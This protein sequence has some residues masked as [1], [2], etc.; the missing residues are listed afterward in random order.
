MLYINT[1]MES[2]LFIKRCFDYNILSR[3]FKNQ[4]YNNVKNKHIII[5]ILQVIESGFFLLL[6]LLYF[7]HS[8]FLSYTY[9]SFKNTS[10]LYLLST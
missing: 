8:C 10:T 9:T 4:Q 7:D 3:I 6:S 2:E 1:M 5:K